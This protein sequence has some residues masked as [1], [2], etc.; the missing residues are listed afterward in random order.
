MLTNTHFQV[1]HQKRK[2]KEAFIHSC[3]LH[4]TVTKYYILGQKVEHMRN[5]P[6]ITAEESTSWNT[7]L[8]QKL[9]PPSLAQQYYIYTK[10]PQTPTK[11]KLLFHESK[12]ELPS[13]I[14]QSKT[15]NI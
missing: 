8:T 4:F 14:R 6:L 9:K 13:A 11:H 7:I 15:D 10:L 2:K 3:P 1:P 12:K 5:P